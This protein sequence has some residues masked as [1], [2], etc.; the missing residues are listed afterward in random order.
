V[1]CNAVMLI[2]H[3]SSC[4]ANMWRGYQRYMSQRINSKR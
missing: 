1:I 4:C 2:F 3:R